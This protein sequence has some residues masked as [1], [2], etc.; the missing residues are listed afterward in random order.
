M[1]FTKRVCVC[2]SFFFLFCVGVFASNIVDRKLFA[3][4]GFSLKRGVCLP[5]RLLHKNKSFLFCLSAKRFKK[6]T[7]PSNGSLVNVL[8]LLLL[9]V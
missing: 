1:L 3:L 4:S 2:L 8:F 9:L 5:Q 6:P 7:H